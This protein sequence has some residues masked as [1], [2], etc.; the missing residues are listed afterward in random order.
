MASDDAIGRQG[1]GR[2]SS[3][4]PAA[5]LTA[6]VPAGGSLQLLVGF[7]PTLLQEA[8]AKVSV[9]LPDPGVPAPGPLVWA[10]PIRGVPLADTRSV[11]FK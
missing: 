5:P 9:E 11:T 10:Y 4:A 7:R 8:E 3:G 1:R 6:T 2:Q